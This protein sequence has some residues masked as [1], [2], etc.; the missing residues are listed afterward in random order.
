M[1]FLFSSV[2]ANESKIVYQLVIPKLV[3]TTKVFFT[4]G[5]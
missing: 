5:C 4:T 1:F 3:F 2:A